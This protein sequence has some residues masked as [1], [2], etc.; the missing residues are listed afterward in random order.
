MYFQKPERNSEYLE[1]ILK[2]QVATL[3]L[4]WTL[5]LEQPVKLHFLKFIFNLIKC[6]LKVYNMKLLNFIL[7]IIHFLIRLIK[8]VF[9]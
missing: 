4:S 8:L 9:D 6:I 3:N 2:K 7:Y 1:E 5:I